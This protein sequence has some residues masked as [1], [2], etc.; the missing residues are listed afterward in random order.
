MGIEVAGGGGAQQ[1]DQRLGDDSPSDGS[2]R[3]ATAGGLG[4]GEET[5]RRERVALRDAGRRLAG[6]RESSVLIETLDAL[7][8]ACGDD[9]GGEVS[10]KLRARLAAERRQALES[11][12]VDD[13]LLA[14][15][16]ADVESARARTAAWSFDVDGFEALGPGLRRIYRRGRNAMRR[17]QKEPSSANLH[18]WRKRVKDLWHAE[19]ILRAASPKRMKKLAQRTHRLAD[20]LGEDHDLGELRHYLASHRECFEDRAAQLALIAVIDRRRAVL[21]DE[22]FA[23]GSKLYRRNPGQFVNAIG[24]RWRQPARPPATAG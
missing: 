8:K 17:A 24:R 16:V 22:A 10:C 19:Q 11:L 13:T 2:K 12:R 15:V 20:L 3:E 1:A 5:Y 23:V 14:A 6:V 9:L 21:Q 4:F 18:N 7:E